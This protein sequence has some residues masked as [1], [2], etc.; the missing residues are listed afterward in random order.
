[1][2]T[3]YVLVYEGDAISAHDT[4]EDAIKAAQRGGFKDTFI[5]STVTYYEGKKQ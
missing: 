4:P 2:K 3:I 5:V 1:M